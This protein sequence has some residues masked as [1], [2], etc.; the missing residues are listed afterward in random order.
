MSFNVPGGSIGKC[1]HRSSKAYRNSSCANKSV[2][3]L[4][5]RNCV[6]KTS[7]GPNNIY[8]ICFYAMRH[9][10]C[11][12]PTAVGN[13]RF[14]SEQFLTILGHA[15]AAGRKRKEQFDNICLGSSRC[16]SRLDNKECRQ[17]EWSLG[18]IS[19]EN[20]S[21]ISHQ[22]CGSYFHLQLI[23]APQGTR[24]IFILVWLSLRRPHC[25]QKLD[26]GS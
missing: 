4:V 1:T 8:D 24:S 5:W 25:V 2:Q 19:G 15:S 11:H 22:F 20:S 9:S 23:I 13:A 3:T 17:R 10:N 6:A 7:A 21:V 12:R 14:G 18:K 26:L 16:G